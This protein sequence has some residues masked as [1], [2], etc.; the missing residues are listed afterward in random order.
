VVR[1][2]HNYVGEVPKT[3]PAPAEEAGARQL[4]VTP[5]GGTVGEVTG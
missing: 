4:A 2:G 3:G 1:G 5:L